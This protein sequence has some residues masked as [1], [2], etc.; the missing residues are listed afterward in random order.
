MGVRMGNLL[1]RVRTDEAVFN[2]GRSRLAQEPGQRAGDRAAR[3]IQE[4]DGKNA[5]SPGST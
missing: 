1:A 5:R 2:A 3:K 4:H